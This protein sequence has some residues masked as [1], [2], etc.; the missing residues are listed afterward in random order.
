[1]HSPPRFPCTARERAR[2]SR[3][4]SPFLFPVGTVPGRH[5]P[6]DTCS[7]CPVT[8]HS[9]D[10]LPCWPEGS[11]RPGCSL[12]LPLGSVRRRRA[13]RWPAP[14]APQAPLCPKANGEITVHCKLPLEWVSPGNQTVAGRWRYPPAN[15]RSGVNGCHGGS[16][17]YWSPVSFRPACWLPA[18][19]S[20]PT[21]ITGLCQGACSPLG[22]R[23]GAPLSTLGLRTREPEEAVAD[24]GVSQGSLPQA[25]C[26]GWGH[27][28]S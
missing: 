5:S 27:G 4:L 17:L 13:T 8:P 24:R 12:A 10:P 23:G 21:D 16:R 19:P 2:G 20:A 15:K 6:A 7:P 14:A 3:G 18:G 22:T 1:M 11:E 28:S 25:R 9:P 26:P